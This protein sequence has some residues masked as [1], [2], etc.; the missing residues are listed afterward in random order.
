M[1]AGYNT[2]LWPNSYAVRKQLRELGYMV[3]LGNS[4]LVNDTKVRSFQKDYNLLNGHYSQEVP[5]RLTVDG[6]A[7]KH[8]LNAMEWAMLADQSWPNYWGWYVDR[9][10]RSRG[11]R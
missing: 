6:V 10:S 4:P 3:P 9:A 11:A 7:G 8:T 1:A 5:G 2:A